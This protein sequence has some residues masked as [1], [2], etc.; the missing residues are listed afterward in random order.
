MSIVNSLST[1]GIHNILRIGAFFI[2]G[3]ILLVGLGK[4]V[5]CELYKMGCSRKYLGDEGYA[6]LNFNSKKVFKKIGWFLLYAGG[7]IVIAGSF[8]LVVGAI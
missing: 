2:L 7:F 6:Y 3:S 4:F 1:F 5:C 8:L